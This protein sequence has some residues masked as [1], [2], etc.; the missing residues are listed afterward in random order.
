M[1]TFVTPLPQARTTGLAAMARRSLA[2]VGQ[3]LRRAIQKAADARARAELL[4]LAD[5]C[6]RSQPN[7]ASELRCAAA[8]NPLA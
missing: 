3:S 5:A 4:N 1:N 7:L 2:G 6:Q 8:Y